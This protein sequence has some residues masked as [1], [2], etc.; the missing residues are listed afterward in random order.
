MLIGRRS[1][2]PRM[3]AHLPVEYAQETLALRLERFFVVWLRGL[4][5]Y[6]RVIRGPASLSTQGELTDPL[7]EDASAYVPILNSCKLY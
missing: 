4:G 6:G 3:H 7:E 2:S 1:Q 5:S